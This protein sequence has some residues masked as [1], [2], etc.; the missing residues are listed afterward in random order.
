MA[1]S[2]LKIRFLL[3]CTLSALLL[4]CLSVAHAGPPARRPRPLLRPPQLLLP[5]VKDEATNQYVTTGLALGDPPVPRKLVVDLGGRFLWVDCESG[6]LSRAYRPGRCMSPECALAASG[7]CHSCLAGPRPGCNNNTCSLFPENP[8]T[9]RN[10]VGELAEDRLSLQLTVTPQNGTRAPSGPFVV[11]PRVLFSCAP[12]LLT[13]GLAP[14]AQGTVGLGRS[15]IALP[16]QLTTSQFKIPPIFALCLSP[17]APSPGVVFFGAGPYTF[18]PGKDLSTALTYTPLFINPVS[19]VRGPTHGEPSDE[20]FVL[21]QSILVNGR[22]VPVNESLLSVDGQGRGGTKVSTVTRFTTL[23][24]SIYHPFVKAFFQEAASMGL[25][26]VRSVAPF[27][28][29]F[30]AGNVTWQ[31]AGPV[32]PA[33]DLVL[34]GENT[35]W[36]IFG[37]NSVVQV[38]RDVLCLAFVDGGANPRTSVVIGGHQLEDNLLQF[39]L[40]NSRLGITPSLLFAQ[41]SCANFRANV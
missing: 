2:F 1:L 37:A 5:V 9:N 4:L 25:V 23:E 8:I 18:L 21:L 34:D 35:T 28:A 22:R 39:D 13:R 38:G 7:G 26:R 14:G 15:R 19:T 27:G 36:R 16:T 41:T 40:V 10:A 32:V 29:C 3:L 20:Y 12:A 17:S 33:V 24:S 6:Y 11:F 31:R 30:G